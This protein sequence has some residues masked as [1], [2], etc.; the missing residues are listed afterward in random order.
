MTTPALRCPRCG[1]RPFGPAG[2]SHRPGSACPQC[3]APLAAEERAPSPDHA[4]FA[5]PLGLEDRGRPSRARRPGGGRAIPPV[6][7]LTVVLAVAIVFQLAGG[8]R[9]ARQVRRLIAAALRGETSL[10]L[11]ARGGASER[12]GPLG[13]FHLVAG[14]WD[15]AAVDADGLWT[16]RFSPPAGVEVTEPDGETWRGEGRVYWERGDEDGLRVLSG[17]YPSTSPCWALARRRGGW[18]SAATG[19]AIAGRCS[20]ASVAPGP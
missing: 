14:T 1:Y 2:G 20:S 15:G 5:R 17:G 11:P 8:G 13:D 19:C 10:T 9:L 3:S 6:R 12:W 16:F 18:R 4:A 7:I